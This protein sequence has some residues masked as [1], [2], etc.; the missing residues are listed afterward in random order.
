MAD[1]KPAVLHHPQARE[2]FQ[3]PAVTG[4]LKPTAEQQAILDAA[5]S[6]ES[7]AISAAA[8]S[9]KTSTLRMIASA[10][11]HTRMLYIAFNKTVQLEADAS[12]P[13]NVTCRTAHALAYRE[14]GAPI[15]ARLNGPRMTGAQ[16]A[17][18][19]GIR[20]P[21]VTGPEQSFSETAQASMAMAMVWRYCRSADT[22]IGSQH[23][24][25]PE[26]LSRD[27]TAQLADHL[28]PF[29]RKAWADLTAGKNGRLKPTHDIYLKQWHL[30]R[31][32]L[33]CWDVVLYDEAQD[34]DP[35]I[36]DVVEHQDHAQLIAVGD[37]AQAIFVWRGAGD[38][39]GRV[40]AKHRLQLTRS[41]RFGA[42]VADEANVWLGVVGTDLRVVGNPLR[43][44]V[45][46]PLA[47]PDAILCRSNAGTIEELLR[48]HDASTKVHLVGGGR[49]MLALAQAADRLQHGRPAGHPELVAFSTWDQLV[50]YVE[51]DPTGSDLAIGVKMIER[52]GAQGVQRA[53][54]G[55]VPAHRADVVVSTAHKSKGL[56][57]G[58]VR[59]GNDF[60]EP[61]DKQ[62]GRPLPIPR[63]DAMLA[64]VSVTRAM[65]ILDTGGL[66]WVHDHLAAL[67]EPEGET[68]AHE[69]K[70]ANEARDLDAPALGAHFASRAATQPGTSAPASSSVLSRHPSPT[71]CRQSSQEPA[72]LPK[73]SNPASVRIDDP[74][75]YLAKRGLAVGQR[76]VVARE[77]GTFVIR[78]VTRDGSLVAYSS[79]QKG[80][81]RFFR[82]EWVAPASREGRG[83]K[84]VAVRS[85]PLECRRARERWALDHGSTTASS[86]DKPGADGS[87]RM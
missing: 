19:L 24:V 39:L 65:G 51:N 1:D 8:G 86:Y 7:I 35:C 32:Q 81:A 25:P 17:R 41:W 22:K 68:I 80:G 83:G 57:W 53:I 66:A 12:F 13:S 79:H 37:S 84:K 55:A 73:A 69:T 16:N 46:A 72:P 11:P 5:S 4:D 27:G 10:R 60:R 67:A 74:A 44:S 77:R 15:R 48:A 42:D 2:R 64:Y 62:T 52:Y 29:A 71:R 9:G 20:S 75:T 49:A 18:A 63:P 50:E 82:P 36:A 34:A 45:L 33:T 30:S 21:V 70:S 23:F 58:K 61:L 76:V 78:S 38:F 87:L 85:A 47:Q 40:N 14:F 28:L 3:G 26:G 43:H 31:P 54:E 6:G 56:E 59:I